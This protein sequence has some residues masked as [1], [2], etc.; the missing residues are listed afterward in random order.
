MRL[1]HSREPLPMPAG[2]HCDRP[3]AEPNCDRSCRWQTPRSTT[4]SDAASF[5]EGST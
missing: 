2:Y 4:W 1:Q 5:R 3:Y